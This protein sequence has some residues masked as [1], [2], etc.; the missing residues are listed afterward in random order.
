MKKIVVDEDRCICC[1]ACFT[2]DPDHFTLG[3][4]NKS[5]VISNENLD[6]SNLQNVIE[7][8]P[9]AAISIV[10]VENEE[11]NETKAKDNCENKDNC[12]C[13]D[14]CEDKEE[15]KDKDNGEDKE[16]CPCHNDCEETD[17]CC[18]HKECDGNCNCEEAN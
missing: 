17:E 18:C 6:S 2:S 13:K 5:T 7:F 16:K 10:E 14:N 1:G 8:C 4:N 3:D 12:Q 15:G 9:T 11:G